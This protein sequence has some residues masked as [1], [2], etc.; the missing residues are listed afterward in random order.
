MKFSGHESF[1]CKSFWLKK[2]YD[3]VVNVKNFN[4]DDAV[5]ELG[6][7]KNMVA[8]IKFWLKAFNLIDND[9]NKTII[10]DKLFSK[11]G[12]DPYLENINTLWLLHYYLVTSEYSSIYSIVF[13]EFR[14]ERFEF[15]KD[16]LYRFI[17]NECEKVNFEPNENT[18]NTD[19]SVFLRTYLKPNKSSTNI[20]DEYSSLLIDLNLIATKG[21]NQKDFV[22]FFN[23]DEKN[24]IQPEIL[25]FIILD[26]YSNSLTIDFNDL[27][28]SPNNIGSVFCI[29]KNGLI[30]KIKYLADKYPF[31]TF[32]DDAGIKQI[33]F[34][35]NIPDKW[36]IL[37][38]FYKNN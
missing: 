11:N 17:V 35:G 25:M 22:Y 32:S 20:E 30:K 9:N 1:P 16:N 21:S 29:T 10:A 3:F 5:I 28:N 18:L 37:N 4:D 15:K 26:K 2:G 24:E 6:V 7:G 14:K 36:D 23:M 31:I 13:N 19:I 34:K 27:L 12:C 8:A 33:Q 38:D